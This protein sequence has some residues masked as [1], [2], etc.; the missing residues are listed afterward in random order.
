MPIPN[1]W[2]ISIYEP[3][4]CEDLVD[5]NYP[6][7]QHCAFSPRSNSQYN[8]SDSPNSLIRKNSHSWFPTSILMMEVMMTKI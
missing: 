1:T 8:N 6:E 2:T 4:Y 7:E 3:L 5:L